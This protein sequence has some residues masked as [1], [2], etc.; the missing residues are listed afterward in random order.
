MAPKPNN[1]NERFHLDHSHTGINSRGKFLSE[2]EKIK[3]DVNL[4]SKLRKALS[5][6]TVNSDKVKLAFKLKYFGLTNQIAHSLVEKFVLNRKYIEQVKEA[7]E[8]IFWDSVKN[9]SGKKEFSAFLLSELN[10]KLHPVA[11]KFVSLEL[12]PILESKKEVL[13]NFFLKC[14]AGGKLSFEDLMRL[15]EAKSDIDRMSNT[16]NQTF[17]ASE[18]AYLPKFFAMTSQEKESWLKHPQL[19]LKLKQFTEDSRVKLLFE[20]NAA[21]KKFEI[22]LRKLQKE[23]G[24]QR[25]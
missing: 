18:L 6:N 9:Y 25:K 24:E 12:R 16:I 8:N 14:S 15:N 1:P 23:M 11:G 19:G 4:I 2:E 5:E 7:T 17:S 21:S 3:H 22:E 20:V 10:E 13:S